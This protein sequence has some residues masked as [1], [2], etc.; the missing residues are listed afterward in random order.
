M[1]RR[2]VALSL[3]L[4][5]ALAAVA[6]VTV[7]VRSSAPSE[8]L[9]LAGARMVTPLLSVRRAPA[10]VD[11][12]VALARLKQALSQALAGT[13]ACLAVDGPGG[14]MVSINDGEALA[15]AS[16]LKLLTATAALSVF[17]PDY[18][19][20]TTVVAPSPPRNGV[21]DRLW[22]VGS[23]DPV[24]STPA[25]RAALA[26]DPVT[27][28]DVT[29]PFEALADGIVAAGVRSVPHGIIG[30][31]HLF[32]TSR[33][34]SLWP[35]RFVANGEI[36]PLGALTVDAGF[37]PPTG[38]RAAD[39]ALNAAA[40]LGS[41]LNAR[42]VDA[43][44]AAH[45]TAPG[46]T[47][48]ITSVSSPP[49]HDIVA[50][51]LASSDNLTAELL[52]RLLGTTVAVP[53]TTQAG[54]KV[55]LQQLRGLGVDTT[56]L[57]VL[58]GSGLSPDDRVPCDVLLDLLQIGDRPHF[59][60]LLDGL[61]VAGER[62]TLAA[63]FVGTPIAGHL[64]AKTGSLDGVTGLAGLLNV[65]V[66]LR[67]AYLANGSFPENAGVSMRERVATVLAS[68]PESPSATALL[69]PPAPPVHTPA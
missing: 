36:G 61:P 38:M 68:Y 29:T 59:R 40:Q 13:N 56:S 11:D 54:V 22:L 60:A 49:L 63:S 53:G 51:M 15:P 19:F 1:T 4:A 16:T 67:F 12:D 34:L 41:L 18:R 33:Q 64:Q 24:L 28:G 69:P 23:G 31:D 42:G 37:V 55:V 50:S 66:P 7:A 20:R 47:T 44:G 32:D 45:A 6:C 3:A 5:C 8:Q 57:N 21:V 27:R 62:G 17:G 26:G 35:A 48:V 25:H 30:D 43:G 9:P 39:P 46:S 10:I 58:D 52:A 14:R 2:H 65:R